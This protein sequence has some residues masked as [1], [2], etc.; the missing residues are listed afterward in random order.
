MAGAIVA[1]GQALPGEHGTYVPM[2]ADSAFVRDEFVRQHALTETQ[3]PCV[4]ILGDSRVAFNIYAA[5]I[6]GKLPNGCTAQNLGFP[7][8]GFRQLKHLVDD[9]NLNQTIVLSAS[10][11]MLNSMDRGSLVDTVLE[12]RWTRYLYLGYHRFVHLVR[13]LKGTAARGSGWTWSSKEK[14]W[15]YAGLERRELVKQPLYEQEARDMAKDYFGARKLANGDG[16]REL[17]EWLIPRTRRVI[18]V[19]PPSAQR[20]Q[21]NALQYNDRQRAMWKLTLQ[22]AND[23]RVTVVDCS[24][25]CVDQSGYAD[26]VHLN[27]RGAA[28]YSEYLAS[29]IASQ[30]NQPSRAD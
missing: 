27:D 16:L 6:D 8:L 21:Q 22:I 9:Y 11:I 2:L 20:F 3:S 13:T 19:I 23:A 4:A 18:I 26:P 10:E 28:Q 12:A 1:I 25:A 7:G 24:S 15:L 30:V 5:T 17:L 14:R 29:Q